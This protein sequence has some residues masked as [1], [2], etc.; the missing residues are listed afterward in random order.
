MCGRYT[1]A[2]T[3]DELVEVFD[4]PPPD[5]QWHPR[6]NIAPGQDAPVVAQGREGRR[7]AL[8]RWGLLPPWAEEVGRGFVNARAE[9]VASKPA[10]RQ[11]FRR[12]RCLVPAD[13]FYEWKKEGGAKLPYWFHP[14]DGGL[15]AFA[16]I[17]QTWSR[18]EGDPLHTYAVLTTDANADVRSV[19]HRM[20]VIVPGDA[21]GVW[22]D[23]KADP[24][25]L[26][27]WLRPAP[28]GWLEARRVS[29]RVNRASEEGPELIQP[30]EE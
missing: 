10:F 6:Y 17:W 12:R 23:P 29:T 9:T 2:A 8:L 25:E 22:L 26:E 11:A 28:D 13:G 1:L 20:P 19:H 14:R 24:E 7:A 18:G 30:V 21:Y 27:R 15:M 4:V 5:F 16:G 3:E